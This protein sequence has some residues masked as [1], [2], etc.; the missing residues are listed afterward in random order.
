MKNRSLFERTSEVGAI[1]NITPLPEFYSQLEK[2]VQD[3]RQSKFTPEQLIG[4]L[5]GKVKLDELKDMAIEDFLKE[6]KRITRKELLEYVRANRVEVQRITKGGNQAGINKPQFESVE[7]RLPGGDEGTYR[8]E[9]LTCRMPL[10]K[11]AGKFEVEEASKAIQPL[12]DKIARDGWQSLTDAENAEFEKLSTIIVSAQFESTINKHWEDG[13]T[14]YY[15]VK[16]PIVRLRYDER[17]I[18]GKKIGAVYELQPPYAENQAKMPELARKR[19][20]ELG[21]K[22]IL[23]I[24]AERGWHAV[25]WVTGEQVAD[26]YGL[27][28]TIREVRWSQEQEHLEAYDLEGKRIIEQDNVPPEK[29]GDYIGKDAAQKLL[30]ESPGEDGSFKYVRILSGLRLKVSGEGVKRLYDRDMVNVFNE[31]GKR[32][33]AKVEY[34]VI[35]AGRGDIPPEAV[36]TRRAGESL[37]ESI[38]RFEGEYA[39][40]II[41]HSLSV[42]SALKSKALGE[43]FTLYSGIPIFEIAKNIRSLYAEAKKIAHQISKT[44]LDLGKGIW[45]VKRRLHSPILRTS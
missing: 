45:G 39:Q 41:V 16:N 19:W 43:G 29:L 26:C 32:L 40:P 18:S 6:K 34:I 28:K 15:D 24:A 20:R 36:F 27:S 2:T 25:T 3:F 4:M 10:K 42:T 30:Q 13:H 1:G 17:T 33:G 11:S 35:K 8:E 37:N 31:L 7:Y 14:G 23:R 44:L 38:A 9:F 21:A 12:R 5:R 22:H